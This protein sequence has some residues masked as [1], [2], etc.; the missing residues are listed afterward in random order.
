MDDYKILA[1]DDNFGSVSV[2]A[3]GIVHV[4]LT[5]LTLRLMPSD[6]EKLADLIAQARANYEHESKP[7][8]KPRLRVVSDKKEDQPEDPQGE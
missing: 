3:G 7:A 2:C 5:H 4:N 6:F 1:N 8:E